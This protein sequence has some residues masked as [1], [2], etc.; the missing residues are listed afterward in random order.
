MCI[1]F[2]PSICYVFPEEAPLCKPF[3]IV[4]YNNDRIGHC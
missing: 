3:P 1:A 2:F 4:L